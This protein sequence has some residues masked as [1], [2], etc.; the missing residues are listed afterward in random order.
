MRAWWTTAAAV[1]AI[2]LGPVAF[3][4]MA[5]VPDYRAAE[6]LMIVNADGSGLQQFV[7]V[8]GY[9]YF[10]SP[11]W[12]RDGSKLAFEA[13]PADDQRRSHVF[14]VRADGS[15]I[16]DLGPGGFPSWSADDG[17]IAFQGVD[18]QAGIWVMNAD[19][20][21]RERLTDNG[22]CPRWS[23]DGTQIAYLGVLPG[24][25]PF[26]GLCSFNT[27]DGSQQPLWAGT[28]Q[29]IHA[30]F[31]W[32]PD[33]KSLALVAMVPPM[34]RQL[35]FL[36]EPGE[37]QKVVVR[38][39]GRDH[40]AL[41]TH[42]AWSSDSKRLLVEYLGGGGDTTPRQLYIFDATSNG[43]PELLLGQDPE[44]YSGDMTWSP[45]GKKIVFASFA[46]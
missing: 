33:G 8:K 15:G 32:S 23:P 42:V 5:Q 13:G 25:A 4:A 19:G 26:Q 46:P 41:G 1:G 7:S 28:R 43:P 37:T 11:T 22:M 9:E 16:R 6:P 35:I 29:Q 38:V 17:R 30:G 34:R 14:V 21:G 12:S 3:P 27:I 40:R 10:S 24:P 39:D 31:Q 44:R 45:D 18:R 20:T 36:Q 2:F